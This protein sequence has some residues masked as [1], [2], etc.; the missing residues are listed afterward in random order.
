[1]SL[2]IAFLDEEKIFIASD[3]RVWCEIPNKGIRVY[4]CIQKIRRLGKTLWMVNSGLGTGTWF[5]YHKI[6]KSKVVK[7]EDIENLE[8][9]FFSEIHNQLL[10]YY[11]IK[12]IPEE[13]PYTGMHFLFAGFD[14]KGYPLLCFISSKNNFEKQYLTQP[15]SYIFSKIDY[16]KIDKLIE[17]KIQTNVVGL[18]KK[19]KGKVDKEIIKSLSSLYENVG[20]ENWGIGSLASFL[21]ASKNK[22]Y[23]KKFHI[24]ERYI[25]SMRL[26]VDMFFYNLQRK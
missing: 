25:D 18:V 26:K 8:P 21:Y 3:A 1:M 24:I 14:S 5:C 17:E 11:R 12:Y 6:R 10:Y 4:D 22:Y 16:N 9:R 15:Y 23:L 19:N 20:K 7:I 2:W 13:D